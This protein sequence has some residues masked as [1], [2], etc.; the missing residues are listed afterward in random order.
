MFWPFKLKTLQ[1]SLT[2]HNKVRLRSFHVHCLKSAPWKIIYAVCS[3]WAGSGVIGGKVEIN[4]SKLTRPAICSGRGGGGW[5]VRIA[6]CNQAYF[7]ISFAPSLHITILDPWTGYTQ[8]SFS[9]IDGVG[10][11]EYM[12]G[13]V[14]H[15]QWYQGDMH[16]KVELTR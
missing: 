7:R 4:N 12:H 8:L 1:N 15:G 3:I 11:M 2:R 13:D 6:A 14:Y 9:I 16:G 5:G 10:T